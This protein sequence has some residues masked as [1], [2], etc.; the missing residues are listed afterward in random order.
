MGQ[1]RT[2]TSAQ[3]DAKQRVA[4]RRRCP[5]CARRNALSTPYELRNPLDTRTVGHART[6]HYCGHTV[7]VRDGQP[8]GREELGGGARPGEG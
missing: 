4:D 3:R 6:C 7:G 5:A 8:F 1:Q 2:D